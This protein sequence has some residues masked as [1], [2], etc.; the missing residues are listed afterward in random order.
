MPGL[1]SSTGFDILGI[2]TRVLAQPNARSLLGPVDFSCSFIVV[3]V[4]KDDNPIAFASPTF[5]ILTGYDN[6]DIVGRN[7]RFLQGAFLSLMTE[8]TPSADFS[9]LPLLDSPGRQG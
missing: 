5:S 3:D 6:K 8:L 4:T 9:F 7:C 1:Y 2:L